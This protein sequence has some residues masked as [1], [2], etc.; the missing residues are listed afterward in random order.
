[1]KPG[2]KLVDL[3]QAADLVGDGDLVYLGGTVLDRKPVALVQA[4]VAAGRK[5]LR[6]ATF[7]GSIDVDLLVAAG[8]T[9]SVASAYV[10]L[11]PIG[12]APRF[13]RA[14][15]AGEVDD[16]EYSEWT[17]LG[18]LRAA[19]MGIPFLPTRGGT[20]SD[21]LGI[22]DFESVGDPYTG[23]T[24]VALA[25]L[26]PDVTLLHAWRAS[27]SGHVQ[28]AW[29]P[30]HLWDVDVVAARA[31]DRVVVS[32]DEIVPETVIAAESQ[33]TRLFA[34]EVD[35][36]VEIP[37]GSWPTSSPPGHEEDLAAL[38]EYRA[39]GGDPRTLA[40]AGVA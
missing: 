34:F 8:A 28:M 29:P 32:V 18:S 17:M 26:R 20:G 5:D 33:Y 35:A 39:S 6:I 23:E 21:I 7:A 13:T 30:Q 14:V 38:A 37:G 15:K 27:P 12:P 22:H 40:A 4:I 16:I 25:P 3:G 24:F 9:R 36:V 10:G 1:V 19:A 31:A 11:G 2:E